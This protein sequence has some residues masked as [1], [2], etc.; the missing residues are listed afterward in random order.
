M[1]PGTPGP[2]AQEPPAFVG[3]TSSSS[4]PDGHEGTSSSS[5]S[6]PSRMKVPVAERALRITWS[7]FPCTM[8][9]GALAS[10]LSQEPF[11]FTGLSV[12]GRVVYVVDLVLFALFAT[13]IAL[14]F[15]RR[16]AMLRA[17]LS[18]P[19]ECFFF[20]SFWVSIALI[21][22]CASAYGVPGLGGAGDGEGGEWLA[23]ALRV[24][25]WMYLACAMLL[26]VFQYHSIFQAERLD[27]HEA[28]PA[29]VMPAYPFLVAGPLAAQIAKS[30]ADGSATQ[31]IIAGIAGQGLGWILAL[32]I[33]NVYFTR[34]IKSDLPP[35][36]ER[37]GMY[38]SVGPAAYTCAGLIALGKQGLTQLPPHFLGLESADARDIWYAVAVPAGLFLWMVAIWFASLTTLSI[39]RGARKMHFALQ[40]WAFVFPN[41]GL[42]IATSKIGV[43]L[44][45]KGIQGV[46]SGLTIVLCMLWILCAVMHVKA[47]WTRDLMYPGKD[48]AIDQAREEID[49]Q[50]GREKKQDV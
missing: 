46:A 18:D 16:P 19:R 33:Y 44:H 11:Q 31:I 39:L 7:W 13:L 1:S 47:V 14:R 10:L 36:S 45:S 32:L 35:P 20:G 29:W 28:V 23:H 2:A 41:V 30:Q 6:S 43:A 49:K 15:G 9:T 37:P 12:I 48:P 24:L 25:F 27:D 17:S 38:I 42:A 34:L 22:Q 21:L 26:A 4:G 40:W 3:E 50:Q 5:S 8:S